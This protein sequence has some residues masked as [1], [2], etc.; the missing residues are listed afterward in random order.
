MGLQFT[1]L[2][3]RSSMAPHG[4]LVATRRSVMGFRE[5][6]WVSHG[7]QVLAPWVWPMGFAMGLPW[8]CHGTPVGNPSV[9]LPHGSPMGFAWVFSGS[10]SGP[11]LGLPHVIGYP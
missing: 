5:S 2:T 10:S 6:L 11:S 7:F 4:P 9:E 8:D 3:N 1:V